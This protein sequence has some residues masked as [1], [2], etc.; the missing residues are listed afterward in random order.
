VG[1]RLTRKAAA[2]NQHQ[3]TATVGASRLNKCHQTQS[4]RADNV[5]RPRSISGFRTAGALV[6]GVADISI[7]HGSRKVGGCPVQGTAL[8]VFD[9]R[10]G[11]RVSTT[12]ELIFNMMSILTQ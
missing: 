10:L 3:T 4:R 1:G 6:N 2:K 12:T 5:P 9:A 11:F 8:S 7:R